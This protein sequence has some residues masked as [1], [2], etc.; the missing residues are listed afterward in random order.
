MGVMNDVVFAEYDAERDC[1]ART[2]LQS[3]TTSQRNIDA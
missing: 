3:L 1:C 2:S